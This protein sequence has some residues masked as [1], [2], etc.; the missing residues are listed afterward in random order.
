MANISIK[1]LNPNLDTAL[2]RDF[3]SGVKRFPRPLSLL[4]HS[5]V[6]RRCNPKLAGLAGEMIFNLQSMW[7]PLFEHM[8]N[9][10]LPQDLSVPG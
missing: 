6:Q 1:S 2:R 10:Q 4:S 3:S 8:A 7:F 5:L 9:V